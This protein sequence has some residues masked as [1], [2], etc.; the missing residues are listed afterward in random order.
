MN[1][2]DL[3][4]SLIGKYGIAATIGFDVRVL[5][6][7]A[8]A[9]VVGRTRYRL[10]KIEQVSARRRGRRVFVFGSGYSLNDIQP[11]EWAHIS[12]HDTVGFNAF[13]R[14][15]WVRTDFHLIRGWGEGASVEFDW[16]SACSELGGL[17]A[18][19]PNY[20]D[21][22]FVVQG[23]LLAEVGNR[24][25]GDGFLRSGADVVRYTTDRDALLPTTSFSRGLAH[26]NGTLCDAVNFAFL[27]GWSEIVLVGVD[28]Y[29]TR[30]FWLPADRTYSTDYGTGR[31]VVSEASDR[32]QRWDQPHSTATNGSVE[33]FGRWARFLSDRG[34]RL[35]VWNPRS[36]LSAVMPVYERPVSA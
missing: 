5:L 8:R 22:T 33:L 3:Q 27:S 4:R 24:M 25:I 23:D 35:S 32:G 19:N 18:V 2:V 26:A 12:A 14:Q 9:A 21:T 7:W 13:V 15:Q 17:I 30:Y 16:L 34:V 31:S 10:L 1:A 20:R 36:L 29:D 11:A 28:L 6:A